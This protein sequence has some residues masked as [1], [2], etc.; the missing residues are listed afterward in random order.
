MNPIL[1]G[2]TFEN[3]HLMGIYF[4]K[5]LKVHFCSGQRQKNLNVATWL[6]HTLRHKPLYSKKLIFK[7]YIN[8]SFCCNGK[9]KE[10]KTCE[11]YLLHNKYVFCSQLYGFKTKL[12]WWTGKV[13][14]AC[15][16]TRGIDGKNKKKCRDDQTIHYD[17][18]P[19]LSSLHKIRLRNIFFMSPGINFNYTNFVSSFC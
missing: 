11:V 4:C 5:N 13:S 17:L 16:G 8:K 6:R 1:L 7:I 14:L 3:S 12:N 9:N 2:S 10:N 19:T 18:M 15:T